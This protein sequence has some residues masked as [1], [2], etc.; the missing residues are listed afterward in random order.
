MENHYLMWKLQAINSFRQPPPPPSPFFQE[1]LVWPPRSYSCSF[2]RRE[3]RSA[4]ALG[5]HMNVHRRDRAKLKQSQPPPP[6]QESSEITST[7]LP[8]MRESNERRWN[9]DDD[10]DS[11]VVDYKRHKLGSCSR[12][13]SMEEKEID[14]ELRLGAPAIKVA[15][16]S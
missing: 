8:L 16:I 3:F 15:Q 7:P 14:L 6:L 2:C 1:S 11:L 5:G 13:S 12:S 4:Q 10:D 9:D